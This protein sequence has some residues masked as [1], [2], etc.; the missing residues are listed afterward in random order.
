MHG[1][2]DMLP[3]L[4]PPAPNRRTAQQ[5]QQAGA[6]E[7]EL[8]AAHTLRLEQLQQLAASP[9]LQLQLQDERLQQMLLQID[10]AGNREAVSRALHAA[11]CP[12][13]LPC[14]AQPLP[15]QGASACC[16]SPQ[17]PAQ[18]GLGGCSRQPLKQQRPE[19]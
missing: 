12:Q 7:S 1:A 15:G 14:E 16:R 4:P 10:G 6:D 19:G 9:E 8:I 3:L 5:Q 11:P 17:Q 13:R 2:S 18:Q